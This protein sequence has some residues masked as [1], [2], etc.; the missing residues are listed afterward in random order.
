MTKDERGL[1]LIGLVG[2]CAVVVLTIFLPCPSTTQAWYTSIALGLMSALVAAQIPGVLNIDFSQAASARVRAG[3]AIAVFALI[4]FVKPTA[5]AGTDEDK[6][7][8]NRS[9]QGPVPEGK[10]LDKSILPK[11][12]NPEIQGSIAPI[13]SLGR[14]VRFTFDYPYGDLAGTRYWTQVK[15][16]VWIETYPDGK[17]FSPFREIGRSTYDSC[18][19]IVVQRQD[20][21]ALKIFIPDKGCEKMWLW[22]QAGGSGWGFLGQMNG[23]E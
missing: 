13:Q 3:G 16:G 8:S 17:L 23:V 1:F 21:T 20:A 11:N 22:A 18:K 6:Q 2:V 15:D 10:E 7:F 19:G 9:C 4:V 14:P 5:L 12:L